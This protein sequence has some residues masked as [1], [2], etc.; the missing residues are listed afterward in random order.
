M[1]QPPS[2]GR[3][4]A[5]ACADVQVFMENCNTISSKS[6]FYVLV[7]LGP[8]SGDLIPTYILLVPSISPSVP[9]AR[10][11]GISKEPETQWLTLTKHK[12]PTTSWCSGEALPLFYGP[13]SHCV[14][15]R[16]ASTYAAVRVALSIP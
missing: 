5:D 4:V 8:A 11:Y 12:Y 14:L 15:T 1:L 9:Y 2:I 13:I 3:Q 16:Y 10:P 6:V 7:M